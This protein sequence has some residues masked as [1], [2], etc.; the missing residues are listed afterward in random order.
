MCEVI[1]N[2]VKILFPCTGNSTRSIFA[3]YLLRRA[4]GDR[5]EVCSAGSFPTGKVNP[6]AIQVL[7]DVYHIDA[8][9]GAPIVAHW[10]IPDPALAEGS[11]EQ[12][13]RQFNRLRTHWPIALIYSARCQLKSWTE[14]GS[15]C[16]FNSSESPVKSQTQTIQAA[17]P[18]ILDH[19]RWRHGDAD[20]LLPTQ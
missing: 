11:D 16:T 7:K 17:R 14:Y 18:Q 19:C 13:L 10:G 12:K 8:S 1:N 3:E 9:G 2:P 6:F 5:F 4:G 20:G 15:L